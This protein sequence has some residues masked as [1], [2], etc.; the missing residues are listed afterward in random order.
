MRDVIIEFTKS[1]LAQVF[2]LLGTVMFIFDAVLA[3]VKSS[4]LGFLA[5]MSHI[6]CITIMLGA[7][8]ISV[9]VIG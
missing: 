5:R 1:P 4:E 6:G 7:F 9:G 3:I 8:L 2:F